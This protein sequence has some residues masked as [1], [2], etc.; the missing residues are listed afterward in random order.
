M[1]TAAR[2]LRYGL[3]VLACLYL[4]YQI[5]GTPMEPIGCQGG[6]E[7]PYMEGCP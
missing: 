6:T 7:C 2:I 5:Q 3:A 1:K 4:L